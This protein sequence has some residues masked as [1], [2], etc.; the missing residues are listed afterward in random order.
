MSSSSSDD[1][2]S[3]DSDT[4]S[5]TSSD[6]NDDDDDDT[7]TTTTELD[8]RREDEWA[9]F[10]L[11]MLPD[12]KQSLT[13][14]HLP[15]SQLHTFDL[16]PE[17]EF[18]RHLPKSKTVYVEPVPLPVTDEQVRVVEKKRKREQRSLKPPK[19][20]KPPKQPKRDP[21]EIKREREEREARRAKAREERE[22]ER[23]RRREAKL[24]G[25]KRAKLFSPKNGGFPEVANP[26]FLALQAFMP[27]TPGPQR[28]EFK[29][30]LMFPELHPHVFYNVRRSW[31][32][33]ERITVAELGEMLSKAGVLPIKDPS[34]PFY[35]EKHVFEA[36][37]RE[38]IKRCFC[39]SKEA[40]LD[41]KLY[42]RLLFCLYFVFS[43]LAFA[44]FEPTQHN[45]KK[46]TNIESLWNEMEEMTMMEVVEDGDTDT[47]VRRPPK[48]KRRIPPTTT[49]TPPKLPHTPLQRDSC[50]RYP[51]YVIQ[52]FG[53]L[54]T[55]YTQRLKGD[56]QRYTDLL[57]P[58][59]TRTQTQT[60][61]TQTTTP[62]PP[63]VQ[64]E[65]Q[66]LPI[67]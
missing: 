20:P 6:I 43:Y 1:S 29:A 67:K 64:E 40:S 4:S 50:L 35:R 41:V 54:H 9:Q 49:T 42:C 21:E 57:P 37:S 33:R 11:H 51:R 5:T 16:P 63:V 2:S 44:F 30:T 38:F 55:H 65:Q 61:T 53:V 23:R 58:I 7:T 15:E 66:P 14:A 17:L 12:S 39:I 48:K 10:Q 25:R 60:Q 45:P 34:D 46:L 19:P 13:R 26:D 28:R 3:S 47:L 27:S 22:E 59:Q 18:E 31:N 36:N 8:K 56:A 62:P 52:L 32:N 24:Q